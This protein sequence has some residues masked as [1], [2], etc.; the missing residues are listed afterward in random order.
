MHRCR[1]EISSGALLLF[2]LL[3]FFDAL[4]LA[5]VAVP[6]IVLHETGHFAALCFCGCSVTRL[7]LGFFG[8]EMDYAG[9]PDDRQMLLCAAAGPLA[10]L[11]FGLAGAAL[12]SRYF[13]M[14]AR[15]SLLLSGFNLLP[16][17]PLDGGRITAVLAGKER[18]VCLGRIAALLLLGCG[19]V[20]LWIFRTWTVLAMA[21][22]LIIL[23]FRT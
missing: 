11:L 7:R 22:W 3:Y 2:A 13:Q 1:L 14:S 4:G 10:G 5:A 18:A 8:M 6:A 12:P 21:I 20:L 16:I 15:F 19:L 23:N 9:A 17:L